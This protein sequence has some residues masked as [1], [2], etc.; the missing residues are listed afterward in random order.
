M[1]NKQTIKEKVLEELIK[2]RISKDSKDLLQKL[3]KSKKYQTFV[4]D[5]SLPTP[6]EEWF[7]MELIKLAIDLTFQ[8]TSKQIFDDIDK[9]NSDNS[10]GIYNGIQV[11]RITD[12]KWNELKKK[13]VK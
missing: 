6:K 13:W 4:L 12:R 3:K 1:K 5:E 2:N 8:E 9:F 7:R 11:V 10:E